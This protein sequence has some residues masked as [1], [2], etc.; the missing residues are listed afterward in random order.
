VLYKPS[1]TLMAIL[2]V[3]AVHGSPQSA[4]DTQTVPLVVAAGTPLRV[5]LT[6]RLSKRLNE[7][8]ESKLLDPLFAFDREVAPAGSQVL[9]TVVRLRPM[10]KMQRAM[11][12]L[13]GDFTPLHKAEVEYTTLVLPDGRR[14]P[15]H[16]VETVGLNSIADLRPP[17]KQPA[18]A[19]Q[20]SGVL[21]TAK[22]QAQTKINA[23]RKSVSDV[24]RG[25]DKKARLA[26]FLWSKLPYHPQGVR[27][28]TRFDAEL[29][30][31]LQFGTATVKPDDLRLFGSQPSADSSV[32]VR[33]ITPLDSNSGRQG[34]PV[35]AIMSRPLFSFD[36]KLVLPEGTRLT[37]VVTMVHR[38]R[39]FR[40]GGQLRFNFQAVDLPDGVKRPELLAEKPGPQTLAT[41]QATEANGKTP[42]KVD[43]EGSVKVTEPKTRFIA[44]LIAAFIATRSADNDANKRTGTPENNTGG[45][46]LGGASGFGL[47]GAAA[48][49]A[50]PKVATALGFYGLAWSVYLNIVARGSEVE[51]QKNAAMDVRF[52]GRTPVPSSKFRA[53]TSTP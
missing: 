27:K 37:G 48:G 6:R 25:P 28:G 4:E 41:L 16:T 35:E 53:S 43:E 14:I 20:N 24:V 12:I 31:P 17:R 50:S 23:A 10:S 5:Y 11:T 26:D 30:D 39:W 2:V 34:E 19:N 3:S 51:F 42:V 21:G 8:V 44:P 33:L 47:L 22:A 52:G 1:A 29:I 40:R 46:V 49:K 9:G 7:P 13:G 15:L 36:H 38:A 32:Q 18:A 45:R